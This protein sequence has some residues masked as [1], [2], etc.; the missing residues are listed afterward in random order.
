M[1]NELRNAYLKML[2]EL[3]G[4]ESK[5]KVYVVSGAPASGKTTYVRQHKQ[6]GDLVFDLDHI[7]AALGGT[8]E[9][10]EDHKPYLDVALAIRDVVYDKIQCREGNWRNAY[11]ITAQ[12]DTSKIKQLVREL[13][14]ELVRIDTPKAKCID[15]ANNDPR[16]QANIEKHIEIINKYF[17]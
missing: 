10:Y 3:A 7:C 17:D 2:R 15:N 5:H 1:Q 13:D 12:K 11:V 8:D 4:D 9:L 14:A 16:R 6:S